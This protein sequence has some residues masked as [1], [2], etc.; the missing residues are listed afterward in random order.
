MVELNGES[1]LPGGMPCQARAVA[2]VLLSEGR[3]KAHENGKN[4]LGVRTAVSIAC[5]TSGNHLT[6]V[7]DVKNS[8]DPVPSIAVSHWHTYLGRYP[9]LGECHED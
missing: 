7:V 8:S 4:V 9:L 5:A 6:G 2:S 3:R 1:R